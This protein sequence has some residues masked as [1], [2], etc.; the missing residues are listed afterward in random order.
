[1]TAAGELAGPEL[2]V[3]VPTYEE[4]SNVMPLV[5]RLGRVLAHWNYEIIF[6]DDHSPDGTAEVVREL[7][8][9]DPRIRII[10]RIG[11]RG[12]ST[13][14]IE[15]LLATA[16]PYGV[17][18]DGDLQH[19]EAVIPKLV[20]ALH[21]GADLAIGSRYLNGGSTGTWSSRRKQVSMFA[22]R[23][24]ALLPSARISDPM[25][26]FFAIRTE[27]F[28]GRAD[29]LVGAGYKILLDILATRGPPISIQE[30]AYAFRPRESGESKLDS[31]VA[32]DFV[33]L[34]LAKTVGRLLPLRFVMF[35]MVGCI[36]VGVHFLALAILFTWEPFGVAQFGATLV[37][38]TGN[39]LL[40]NWFTYSDKRLRGAQLLTGWLSFCAASSVGLIA[41]TGVA[42]Y[43]YDTVMLSWY[44]AALA[45]ILVGAVWNYVS[46]SLFTWK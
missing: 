45:G 2:A 20:D 38:M 44:V 1:M 43:L 4:S 18:I 14:V 23:M 24:C 34:L 39:F 7:S 16:A 8:R 17:V 31:R 35:L 46:T 30:V 26:G 21:N 32:L 3:I 11:R 41:N 10:E 40:N 13:A 25:S 5:E 42:V 29:Q 28:R 33:K 27:F 36:G 37:A 22:T 12:L 19:D 6:V 9:Q 15:G